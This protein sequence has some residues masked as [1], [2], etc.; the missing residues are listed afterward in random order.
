MTCPS[1]LLKYLTNFLLRNYRLYF[2]DHL[3]FL[4]ICNDFKTLTDYFFNTYLMTSL[5]ACITISSASVCGF[6][7]FAMFS[8][9]LYEAINPP[10]IST[11]I[12]IF[13]YE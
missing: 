10:L 7:L 12:F 11:L 13:L 2:F 3:P 5:I 9:I 6:P 4:R 8:E 1:S